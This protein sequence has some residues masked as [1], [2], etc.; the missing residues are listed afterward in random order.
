MPPVLG[1]QEAG[2]TALR[3][4]DASRTRFKDC[5]R[6][7]VSAPGGFLFAPWGLTWLTRRAPRRR[8]TRGAGVANSAP[9]S[10]GVGLAPEGTSQWGRKPIGVVEDG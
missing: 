8:G 9:C 6:A 10:G 3:V 4:S 7:R 2:F 5:P 1:E